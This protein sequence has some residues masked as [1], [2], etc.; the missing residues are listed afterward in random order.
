[1]SRA[2]A[3]G[4]RRFLRSLLLVVL[5]LGAAALSLWRL[6]RLPPGW[7]A[8]PDAEDAQVQS[9]AGQVEHRLA[10][11]V[12]RLREGDEPWTVRIHEDQVNAW[13]AARL[14]AWAAH[15]RD[16]EWPQGL[17][18]PQVRIRPRGIGVALEV[19]VR[20]RPRYV[21]V[22]LAPRIEN[23]RLRLGLDRAAL[24]RIP[25]PGD[26]LETIA[27]FLGRALPEVVDGAEAERVVAVLAGQDTIEAALTLADGRRVRL[28]SFQAGDGTLDLTCRTESPG[29][30]DAPAAAAPVPP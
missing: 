24:G 20:G 19:L 27:P 16:L 3:R 6:S 11:E 8:P 4:R 13:L 23:G 17:G 10:E 14:R 18:A 29:A 2:L 15:E 1:M 26:P 30:P 25:V 5:V 28:M 22:R 21:Q 12:H 9:Y 7:W